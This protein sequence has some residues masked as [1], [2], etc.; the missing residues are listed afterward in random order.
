MPV[1]A[2]WPLARSPHRTVVARATHGLATHGLATRRLAT[3]RLATRRLAT[4]RP[5]TH[6]PG[7]PLPGLL[8][9]RRKPPE[10]ALSPKRICYV[11][12]LRTVVSASQRRPDGREERAPGKAGPASCI[13]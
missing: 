9:R 7:H 6:G 1:L 2:G 5:A 11:S 13:S 12:Q 3:R 8:D 4:R 10:S